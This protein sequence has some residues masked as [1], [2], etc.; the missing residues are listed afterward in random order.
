LK[1]Q[2]N[3]WIIYNINGSDHVY[4]MQVT[5][6]IEE[7]NNYYVLNIFFPFSKTEKQRLILKKRN[8][9]TVFSKRVLYSPLTKEIFKQYDLLLPN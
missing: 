6:I 5:E 3:N 7:H 9:M 4:L 2:R 1:I 8:I